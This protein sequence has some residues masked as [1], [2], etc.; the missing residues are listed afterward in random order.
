MRR[1][2]ATSP[3]P[4]TGSPARRRDDRM[5]DQLVASVRP[6]GAAARRGRLARRRA[7]RRPGARRARRGGLRPGQRPL[8]R[9]RPGRGRSR[10]A[11]ERRA[12]R[13]RRGGR[14]AH[15]PGPPGRRSARGRA[16]GGW[17]ALC[18]P[19]AVSPAVNAGGDLAAMLL[20]L[21][22][23]PAARWAR[24]SSASVA[25]WPATTRPP[26]T[27]SSRPATSRPRS[28][29][30]SPSR[31]AAGR[32]SRARRSCPRRRPPRSTARSPRRSPP[33]ASCA[34]RR[35]RSTAR[36]PPSTCSCS[37]G[38]LYLLKTGF[39]EAHRKLAPGL[40]LRLSVIERCFEL[41]LASHELLGDRSEWK[42]KFAT[43]E[44]PHVVWT[45]YSRALQATRRWAYRRGG[46]ALRRVVR[47]ERA[48]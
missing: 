32:A 1:G 15:A 24:G 25:R 16:A 6:R 13:P 28:R 35:S 18:T 31:A 33:A 12:R 47:R 9:V 38:R 4:G 46:R 26:W 41:G 45:G 48:T 3:R 19:A 20:L 43:T 36:W 37:G 17:R 8:A 44:R 14:G 5:A 11:R 39:D 42:A 30:A 23:A 40:V 27:S 34:P 22:P 21:A 29:T 10:R 2:S 7:G